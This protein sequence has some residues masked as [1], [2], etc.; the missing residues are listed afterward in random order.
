MH[1]K[2]ATPASS[3]GHRASFAALCAGAIAFTAVGV[4]AQEESPPVPA[5]AAPAPVPDDMVSFASFSEPVDIN[6][7]L[8]YVQR[9]LGI[10]I[11]SDPTLAGTVALNAPIEFPR[12]KLLQVFNALLEQRGFVM[13]YDPVTNFYAV[14][15]TGKLSPMFGG[16]LGTTRVIRTPNV[17]PSALVTAIGAQLGTGQAGANRVTA[18]DD[19]GVLIVTDTPQRL[20]MVEGLIGKLIEEHNRIELVVLEVEH[21]GAVTARDQIV[22]L[23]GNIAQTATGGGQMGSQPPGGE[24][25]A[26]QSGLTGLSN[27]ERRL[28]VAPQGNALL[29]RGTAAEAEQIRELLTIIDRPNTLEPKRYFTG[30]ATRNIAQ[31]ASNIG[32]GRLREFQSDFG[33]Y[34]GASGVQFNAQTGQIQQETATGGSFMISDPSNGY[35]VFFGTPAQQTQFAKLVETFRTEGEVPVVRVYKLKYSRADKIAEVVQSL[36]TGQQQTQGGLLGGLGQPGGAPPAAFFPMPEPSLSPGPGG[37]EAFTG[38][39]NVYAIANEANN[40][41]VVKAPLKQQAEFQ[42]LIERLDE[43]RAQVYVE[44]TIVAVNA[45]EDFR[46][47]FE[48]QLINAQGKG[49]AFRTNFGLT[50]AVEDASFIDPVQVRADLLGGTFAMIQTDYVPIIISALQTNV[51]GRIVSKPQLLVNDNEETVIASVNTFPFQTQSQTNNSTLTSFEG[52]AEAGTT[53]RVLPQITGDGSVNLRYAIELSSFTGQP[54]AEGAPPPSQKNTVGSKDSLGSEEESGG[55]GSVSVP[56][57][58]TVVVGGLQFKNAGKTIVRLPFFGDI[59][60]VG[61]LFRDTQK[62]EEIT[63]LY[64]FI[65][66]RILDDPNFNDLLLLTK[67]P[68]ADMGL[69]DKLPPMKPM[70]IDLSGRPVAVPSARPA[71]P[72]RI[73]GPGESD[74]GY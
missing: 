53:F 55:A 58:M 9:S 51:D 56:T 70:T 21:I 2:P 13:T 71:E 72:G 18:S 73:R 66:P 25:P 59:P 33:T 49:G 14:Q 37:T 17:K 16:T 34:A 68:Q 64:I 30:S 20:D 36:I 54:P 47:R 19:L 60:I 22:Q 39:D 4:R 42:S 31:H 28:G 43:R 23:T 7:L 1:S 15:P 40:Q 12:S 3:T 46:L 67:G 48:T 32:L 26:A 62:R 61:H 69:D 35:I 6:V 29:F 38:G 24:Q 11:N 45:T 57:G 27:F 41:V 50:R 5:A 44:A 65:T 8:Q 63:T 52:Q 10:N 74:D